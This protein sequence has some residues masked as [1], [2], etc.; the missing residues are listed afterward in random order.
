[1][2][3]I[4][5]G[6]LIQET[7]V[8]EFHSCGIWP[9]ASYINHCCY[10]NARRSFIGDM[11]I[12]RATQD[13]APETEVT[14]WYQPPIPSGYRERQKKLL[15][16]WDFT[17]DCAICQD[18]EKSGENVQ[19]ARKSLRDDFLRRLAKVD[20][21]AVAKAETILAAMEATYQRPAHE[22]PRLSLRDMQLVLARA[23]WKGLQ[24]V[25]TVEL[26]LGALQSLGYETTAGVC[27][28]VGVER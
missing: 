27:G 25:K 13:L 16:K 3:A 15:Q 4:N 2:R 18:D 7:A 10:S 24:P 11:M 21:T 6:W 5:Q 14:F 8:D 12:V 17:C 23:S 1:M 22:V 26:A 28:I 20:Q 19:A 9:T